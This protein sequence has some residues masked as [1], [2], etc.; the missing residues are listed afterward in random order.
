MEEPECEHAA[1]RE[2]EIEEADG[3]VLEVRTPRYDWTDTR[4]VTYLACRNGYL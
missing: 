3:H 1:G 2:R 4:R